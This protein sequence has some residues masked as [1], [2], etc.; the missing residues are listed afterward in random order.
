MSDKLGPLEIEIALRSINVSQ[1]AKSIKAEIQGVSDITEKEVSKTNKILASIGTFAG[2]Y[3]GVQKLLLELG[4]LK[5]QIINIRGEYEQAQIAFET[6][7]GSKDKADNLM[8]KIAELAAKTPF[9]QREVV[10]GTKKLLAYQ[11][12]VD[13][14]ID[15]MRRLGDIAAGLSVP[16]DR[17]I[18]V[19]GQV[20]AKGRLMGDDLRQFTEA[21]IPI[22]HELA[23]V[24]GIADKEVVKLVSDG[25]VGFEQV[26]KVISNLTNEGGMFYNLMEKQSQSLTGKVSN[27]RDAWDRLL[28]KLGE[29]KIWKDVIGFLT[30]TIDKLREFI[31]GTEELGKQ[32]GKS[33]AEK[34]KEILSGK[35]EDEAFK[36]ITDRIGILEKL[37]QAEGM[38]LEQLEKENK[39][40]KWFP[41][42]VNAYNIAIDKS[43]GIIKSYVTELNE[44]KQ[45]LSDP[46]WYKK[47]NPPPP[48]SVTEFDIE[49]YKN[50]LT[51]IQNAY[52]ERDAL[53]R[54]GFSKD[55]EKYYG[56]LSQYGSKWLDFLKKEASKEL[57]AE[58]QKIVLSFLVKEI[59]EENKYFL[60][61]SERILKA[62]KER[63]DNIKVALGDN[64]DKLAGSKIE[65]ELSVIAEQARRQSMQIVNLTN[66]WKLFLQTADASEIAQYLNQAVAIVDLFNR[67]L[68]DALNFTA[69]IAE[70]MA[71]FASGDYLGGFLQAIGSL[72]S[73]EKQLQE[74]KKQKEEKASIERQEYSNKLIEEANKLLEYQIKLLEKINGPAIYSGIIQSQEALNKALNESSKAIDNLN[75]KNLND[76]YEKMGWYWEGIKLMYGKRIKYRQYDFS[77]LNE[78]MQS[79]LNEPDYDNIKKAY[80]KIA[81]I[82]A[83]I[84]NGTIF[85]D[86]AALKEQLD[87]YEQL[88]DKAEEFANK[89][90]EILTGSTYDSVVDALV[91]A[92]DDG[93]YSAEEFA[94]SFEKLMQTAVLNALKINALK[95]PLEDWYKEFAKLSENGLTKEEVEKLR[96]DYMQLAD[97]AGK[98]FEEMKN[99]TGIDFAKSIEDT[100][101]TGAIKGMSEET[102]S[103]LAGQFN[104]LRIN[105]AEHLNIA[106]QALIYQFQIAGNTA[107]A[108]RLLSESNSILSQKLTSIESKLNDDIRGL[109]L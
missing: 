47:I 101:L 18:V 39:V 15:T 63:R 12:S 91:S 17:L 81:E 50:Q 103:I 79:A 96:A 86:T 95:G 56:Y 11:E 58:A 34:L 61:V 87:N 4:K 14:V 42:P 90:S 32:I 88:I 13:T 45:L 52:K 69:G 60:Q 77:A 41:V 107:E 54:T 5:D 100:S 99:I 72:L 92:F 53:I 57:P 94:N 40:Y 73:L 102:A 108:V 76:R 85:G 62:F 48:D 55:A 6:M 93:I 98:A 9:S 28:I 49:A 24:F 33:S 83:L 27:M 16:I 36:L 30:K 29:G 75:I 84:K 67:E 3:L 97:N 8:G 44:L 43:K 19:Y 38:H 31:E 46:S 51:E 65:K 7:L 64:A 105:S 80:E 89:R 68:G 26:R 74:R 59:E 37:R 104:A 82:R 25:K 1:V 23:K 35:S 22:I 10:E 21:G 70:S 66:K 20:K 71:K 2:G 78:A 106:R 109:G